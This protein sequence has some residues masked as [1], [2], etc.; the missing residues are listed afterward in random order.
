MAPQS[1]WPM[2]SLNP[3]SLRRTVHDAVSWAELR[4]RL[5]TGRQLR[6]K[7]GVDATAPE[8]HLGHAVNY[9]TMRTLQE[10]GH[11]LVFL[12]GDVTSGIGDPTG[13]ATIRPQLSREQIE[14][15][16]A[17]FVEQVATIVH[18]DP[19]VFEVRRSSEWYDQLPVR[20][21]LAV[22]S[23]VTHARLLGRDM[24]QQRLADGGELRMH[25]LLYPILQ[26]YDSFALE[27]DM[28]VCGSDQLFNEMMG[29]TI[30]QQLGQPP[31]VVLTTKITPGIDG[32]DK[33]SKTFG[34]YIAINDPPR[35]KFGKL[36]SIPDELIV[37]YLEVY[38][39]VPLA[40]IARLAR[41]MRS[42]ELNP[43]N[44]KRQLARAVVARYHGPEQAHIEDDWFAERFSRRRPPLDAPEVVIEPD[45]SAVEAVRACLPG[46]SLSQIR[47]LIDQGAV[48][49][50]G[51]RITESD[52]SLD[53][54][55]GDILRI[56]K[57]RWFRIRIRAA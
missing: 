18:T 8:L 52:S 15:N 21:F 43:M 55:D 57:R 28:T 1:S 46:E 41:V 32:G 34:N 33:Q 56:G 44:A 13:R 4:E 53:I 19:D 6:I 49:L 31:Q 25:E 2:R 17:S 45:A 26:G 38:S 16:S 22:L 36:M 30:Q 3:D 39:D 47:R 40:D 51:N 20:D 11:K 42:G 29:R 14:A 5:Q 48:T 37:A 10:H 54:A 9:W 50:R 23:Q 27:A 35:E 7:H 24:F 12:I